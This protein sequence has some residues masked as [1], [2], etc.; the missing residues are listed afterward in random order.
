MKVVL[1]GSDLGSVEPLVARHGLE[2]VTRN[3]EV[4]I[5]VGGDGTLLSAEREFPG[6]PKL[7]LR[8]S[9]TSRK[10]HNHSWEFLLGR[11]ARGELVLTTQMKLVCLCG[12][13]KLFGLND[14]IFHNEVIT[15]AV[16]YTVAINGER[17]SGEIIGDGL[18]VATPFGSTAYYRSITHSIFQV[19]IGMAFNNSTEPLQHLVLSEDS[20]IEVRVLRGPALVAADNDRNWISMAEGDTFTVHKAEHS[21]HI[22]AVPP[23]IL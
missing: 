9:A 20:V 6:V 1:F 5:S 22:L 14:I 16:R 8:Q 23:E 18:I 10:I 17:Q 2:R 3:P 7:P 4:V 19:G 15:S 12:D 13:R 21:A 11:L